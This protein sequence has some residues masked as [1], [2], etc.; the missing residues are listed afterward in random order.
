LANFHQT[1]EK[2]RQKA[3]YDKHIK[4]KTFAQGDQVL[5]YDSKYQKHPRKLHMHWLGPFIVAK[6]HESSVVRLSQLDGILS[7]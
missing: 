7:P 5:L 3:W 6:I 1:V 4:A 2:A